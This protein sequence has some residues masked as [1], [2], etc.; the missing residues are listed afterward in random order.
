MMLI[1]KSFNTGEVVLNYAEGPDNGPPIVLIHGFPR[2]WKDFKP[3]IPELSKSN[4]VYAI[5]LRGHGSSGRSNSYMFSDY[6]RD[7]IKLLENKIK[8]PAVLFG[9][10]LGG[11]ISLMIASTHPRLVKALIIGDSP[12]NIINRQGMEN[13]VVARISDWKKAN[14]D[15]SKL[16][17]DSTK[18]LRQLDLRVFDPW[19]NIGSDLSAFESLL[20]GYD[21][22]T[23]L[24]SIAEVDLSVLLIQGNTN[25]VSDSDVEYAKSMLQDLRH[26]YLE[27]HGHYLGLINGEIT[28]LGNA[29]LPFL[30]SLK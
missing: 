11:W 17:Y 29:L 6:K 20:R 27:N 19:K 10:S 8:Q 22:E 4:H 14:D 3:I 12:L 9:H 18:R 24:N 5:D 21:L 30:E 25:T 7:V 28:D 13:Y 15:A 1:E 2:W 16:T 23:I 26:V